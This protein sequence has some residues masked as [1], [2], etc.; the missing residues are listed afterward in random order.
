MPLSKKRKITSEI[1]ADRREEAI[2]HAPLTATNTEQ[3][4]PLQTG[5]AS[6]SANAISQDSTENEEKLQSANAERQARFKAL[7]ARAVGYQKQAHSSSRFMCAN[8][9]VEII[10][11]KEPERSR[12]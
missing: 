1:E 3:A 8:I 5:S 6:E 7:Q 11:A 4:T 2:S 12:R 10:S 9:E